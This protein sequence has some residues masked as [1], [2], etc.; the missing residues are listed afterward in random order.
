MLMLPDFRVRQRDF[1]LQILRAITAQLDLSEVMR[2]VLHASIAMMAGQSGLVALRAADG[3]FYVRAVSGINSDLIPVLNRHLLELIEGF[4]EESDPEA[5]NEYLREMAAAINPELR[6]SIALPLIFASNPLGMLIIFRSY[7]SAVTQNDLQ[8]LQSFAD[9]A[10]IAVHNAQLYE[11]INQERTRLQAILDHSAD[12]IMILD[13]DLTITRLNQAAERLTGWRESDALEHPYDEIFVLERTQG[14]D[15]KLAMDEGW[16]FNNTDEPER[17]TL[18]MEGDLRLHDGS[19]VGVGITFAPM[20]TEGRLGHIVA[21]VRDITNYRQA[22]EMQNLFISGISHELKTPVA[23]IKGYAATLRREDAEWDAATLDNML[24]VIEDEADRL[25]DLIQNLLTASK[26]QA[27]HELKLD[28]SED[29]SLPELAKRTVERLKTQSSVHRFVLHFPKNYPLIAADETQLRQVL[30]NLLSNALKYSPSGG[31]IEVGGDFDANT[32]SLY[33]QDEGVGI[34]ERDKERV[35]ERF[36][37]ADSKLSRRTQGT[38]LGLYLAKAII[39]AHHGMIGLESALGKGS[40]FYFRLP[41]QRT[42][43]KSINGDHNDNA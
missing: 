18:Y 13:R 10:A 20:L 8:V 5:A 14:V 43:Y 16:P 6:Q 9:Q 31:A 11:E 24:S 38:G 19:F 7:R 22:Q 4:G 25:T 33:V 12:G 21:N 42:N 32:V 3:Y 27:Q 28:I 15:L 35:F 40:R 37:R 30:D 1:L 34:S 23:I 26:I 39:D 36:Y 29:V 2:R 41:I 17:N